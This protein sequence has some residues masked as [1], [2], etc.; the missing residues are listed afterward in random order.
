MTLRRIVALLALFALLSSSIGGYLYYRS[1]KDA[2]IREA[3]GEL[4]VRTQ[5]L[6]DRLARLIS[7]NEMEVRALAL[8]EE[9]QEALLN[10]S[11]ATVSQADRILDHFVAGLGDDVCY[12]LDRNGTAIASSNRLKPDSFVGRSYSFRPYFRDALDGK[13]SKYLALGETS[14]V[15]GLYFGHPVY[16]PGN[17]TPIGVAVVKAPIEGVQ[18][19]FSQVQGGT[20]LLVHRSGM[21]FVS[22]QPDW[23]FNFLWRANPEEE[24]RIVKSKQFGNGPWKWT[25]LVKKAENRAVAQS[26]ETYIIRERNVGNCPGWRVVY[27]YDL[28]SMSSK[29][30]DPLVG[31]TGYVSLALVLLVILAVVLLHRTAEKE[32]RTRK[33]TEEAL[34]ESEQR[35]RQLYENL[36]DG[37]AAVSTDGKITE[38]NPAFAE[39]LGYSGEELYRLS[40]E[41]ITP[42]K[43]H[44]AEAEIIQSQ[45]LQRGYSDVYEKEYVRKDGTIFPVELRTYLIPD[46]KVGYAGMWAFVRD[47]S[48]RKSAEMEAGIEKLRFETLA[49]N[50]P[51]G[52]VMI[53][54]DGAFQ[55]INPKFREI[56]GYDA[57]DVPNGREWFKRAYP[58]SVYR[59]QVIRTW[60]EDARKAKE[61]QPRPRTF[62][63]TCKDGSHKTVHFVPVQLATGQHLMACEDVT[64]RRKLEEERDRL[65]ALSMDML[66]VAG[67]DGLFKQLNP[68]WTKTLGWSIDDLLSK[69]YIEFVHPD[70]REGTANAGKKLLS[71]ESIH[72]YENRYACKDGSYRWISWNSFPLD[73]EKL[74][75]AVA[76]DI[77]DRKNSEF[78]LEENRS[79]LR[80]VLDHLP[81][82]LWMKDVQGRFLLVN[83]AFA[84]ACGRS[85]S[86]DVMGNTDFDIWPEEL[87]RLYTADDKAV[88]ANGI[89]KWIEEPIIDRGLV[90]WFETF[91]TP[92]VDAQGQVVGTVGSARD[93]TLRKTSEQ[94]LRQSEE[95]YRKILET[96]A[97][98]Y[99]EVDLAGNLTLVNDS[100]CEILGYSRDELLGM[101]Y[102]GLM[103]DQNAGE[104][105]HAYNAVYRS[106]IPNPEFSYQVIRKDGSVR[107]VSV[108]IALMRDSGGDPN[109]FRGIFRDITERRH[110]EE[111]LRQA[112]KMEAIG[113]L[114]G[115]IAHDFNNLLT[116]I[117][118]YTTILSLE[119][120]EVKGARRK[121]DQI[122]RAAARAADL[123]RQLLAF[124]R[125]QV[126]DVGVVNLNDLV[127]D[128]ESMLRRLIGEDVELITELARHIGNVRADS[129]QLEQV[130]VN[131]AVNA[132]DAMP[133]GGTLCVETSDVVLDEVYCA[134]HTEIKPGP[135]VMLSMSDT[136]HGMTAETC[137]RAFDPFFT[138]KPKGAGTGLGLSTVYGIIKQHGGHVALYSEVGRGTTFK[139]YIPRVDEYAQIGSRESHSEDRPSG[140]ETILLVEDE[141]MV[142]DLAAEALEML[143]YRVLRAA[144]PSE[145]AE[146]AASHPGEIHLLLTDVVLPQ[147]D[148]KTLYKSLIKNR[149]GMKVLYVS[150]Y[151]ENFIVHRGILDPEVSFLQKPFTVDSIARK[152][153]MVLDHE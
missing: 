105:F 44:R 150:G 80:A 138:T 87:A 49:E 82:M 86:E 43:W 61:G 115:G 118:G 46:D 147:M 96:I 58:D 149:S 92:L 109:G 94:A 70:D 97:D 11:P 27:L 38:F 66:S 62:T 137:A 95:K 88:I 101:S 116:A 77:T 10:T 8:F 146:I 39:M 2:A 34:T 17:S 47:I 36:R 110:L 15:R 67:F 28:R 144:S 123:T 90:K 111:Q 143:G 32:I 65:F 52:L 93:I 99:H 89:P 124:S 72:G 102:R 14:G 23:L 135:Y 140:N 114:A 48:D 84:K 22:A 91:K 55:Y 42:E 1:A 5:L 151:T 54:E 13:P 56:F 131:L 33:Q 3:E 133:R 152:V 122:N 19:E 126:L 142:R 9:L 69:P 75:F 12:L 71:G 100:L 21:I 119:I 120:P 7:A 51:F 31:I 18:R 83:Q 68:A 79:R 30:V 73:D 59:R 16:Q 35:Y 104:I 132:R 24:H 78:A 45:V 153:R 145:A 6:A 37:L 106:G 128:I 4:A 125:K 85:F 141:E 57:M 136:G 63:V 50:A 108:S 29:L 127:R 130:V 117:M 139:V 81:D 41:D 129:T 40:Y 121:L 76:R 113:R 74:I 107:D 112:V 60:L 26:G 148:G 98:G 64:K 25:G 103:D 53:A 134:S 20:P